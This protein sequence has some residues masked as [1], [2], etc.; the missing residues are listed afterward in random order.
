MIPWLRLAAI[1][2]VLAGAFGSGWQVRDW[3]ADAADLKREQAEAKDA[4]R[5]AEI[6]ARSA[7]QFE[8]V[9]DAIQRD[10]RA[11]QARLAAALAAPLQ[12]PATVG[13]VVVPA[14]AVRLLRDAAG[15]GDDDPG[16]SRPPVQPGAGTAGG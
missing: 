1:A 16:E 12:C 3:Q 7:Q 6:A 5:R 2:A 9:R 14:A 4:L 13:D 8:E 15:D 11:S 10:L